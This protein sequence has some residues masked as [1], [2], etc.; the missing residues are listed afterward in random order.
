MLD[1]RE[2]MTRGGQAELAKP[3][4]IA[5]V[6]G[7]KELIL[8]RLITLAPDQTTLFT[9]YRSEMLALDDII[10]TVES[11]IANGQ[12]AINRVQGNEPAQKAGIL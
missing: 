9:V 6:T 12:N 8:D 1:D 11:D 3:Y 4:I 10:T 5:L 2:L 7:A